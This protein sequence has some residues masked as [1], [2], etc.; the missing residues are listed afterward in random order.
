M[1]SAEPLFLGVFTKCLLKSPSST[2]PPPLCPETFLVMHVHFGII[3]SAKHPSQIFESVLNTPIR[4]ITA[5]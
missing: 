1:F 4:L 3:L 2:I 5:Q